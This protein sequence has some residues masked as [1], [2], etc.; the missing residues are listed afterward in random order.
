MTGKRTAGAT[1][2]ARKRS[3]ATSGQ[4]R[5]CEGALNLE[6][7]PW[8][9]TFKVRMD[10]LLLENGT[11]SKALDFLVAERG[12]WQELVDAHFPPS[13]GVSYLQNWDKTGLCNI[14]LWQ[15]CWHVDAGQ[16]GHVLHERFKNL[17][18]LIL[19]NGF[20][21]DIT[22]VGGEVLV[23]EP[24]RPKLE[25]EKVIVDVQG[26]GLGVGSVCFVKGWRRCMAA[27]FVIALLLDIEA[28][29]DYRKMA[30]PKILE[31]FANVKANFVSVSA[32]QAIEMN[33]G[34]GPQKLNKKV[35]LHYFE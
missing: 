22:E 16:T 12:Q 13:P 25:V 31:S 14:H 21:T 33:R 24:P 4:A 5:I 3:K 19:G 6:E 18:L 32:V 11:P 30:T 28:L 35:E 29:D 7:A 10:A 15:G 8:F 34:N 1:G 17:C 20:T 9:E 27:N 2:G 23:I 26:E